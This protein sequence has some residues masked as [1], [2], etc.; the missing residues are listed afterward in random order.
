L[1][2]CKLGIIDSVVVLAKVLHQN[3]FIKSYYNQI[4]Y[5]AGLPVVSRKI[6]KICLE[7]LEVYFVKRCSEKT[8]LSSQKLIPTKNSNL[9]LKFILKNVVISKHGTHPMF[10][11]DIDNLTL[12]KFGG[13]NL[14]LA[15]PHKHVHESAVL[16]CSQSP[17]IDMTIC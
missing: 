1:W 14:G 5:V 16:L 4:L 17:Q 12:L 3:L 9:I 15:K 6:Y 13:V 2:S 11:S 8:E 7:E 10:Y